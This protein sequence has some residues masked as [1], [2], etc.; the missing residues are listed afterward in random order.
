MVFPSVYITPQPTNNTAV[1]RYGYA[2][3]PQISPLFSKQ[4]IQTIMIMLNYLNLFSILLYAS[5]GAVKLS[6]SSVDNSRR[7]TKQDGYVFAG[8]L[9]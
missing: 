1:R 4:I 6:S 7:R 3:L 5:A 2:K 8:A 9:C